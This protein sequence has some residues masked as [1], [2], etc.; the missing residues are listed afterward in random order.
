MQVKAHQGPA[1]PPVQPQLQKKLGLGVDIGR[2]KPTQDLSI[3]QFNLI[4]QRPWQRPAK[5]QKSNG[6]IIPREILLSKALRKMIRD[7]VGWPENEVF[8]L[9]SLDRRVRR[10]KVISVANLS[11]VSGSEKKKSALMNTTNEMKLLFPALRARQETCV[12]G[13]LHR[14]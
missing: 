4:S 10:E 11:D 3:H 7:T 2:L 5:R 1:H 6:G 13:T 9:W 8:L 12:Q 14:F